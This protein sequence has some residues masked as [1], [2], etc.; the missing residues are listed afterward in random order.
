GDLL[1]EQE[2]PEEVQTQACALKFLYVAVNGAWAQSVFTS[3]P[4]VAQFSAFHRL[5]YILMAWFFG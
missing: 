3:P 4:L 1:E 5:E 2:E